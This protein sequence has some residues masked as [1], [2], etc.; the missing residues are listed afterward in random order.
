MTSIFQRTVKEWRV[1]FWIMVVVLVITNFVYVC[2]GSGE[3]QPW[4]E[5]AEDESSKSK[6]SKSHDKEVVEKV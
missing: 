6:E 5:P 4:N 3:Q 2:F 1:V